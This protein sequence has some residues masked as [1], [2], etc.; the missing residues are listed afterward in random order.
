[1]FTASRRIAVPSKTAVM[2]T[3]LRGK[4]ESATGRDGSS[5][6]PSPCSSRGGRRSHALLPI[7]LMIVVLSAI[8]TQQSLYIVRQVTVFMPDRKSLAEAGF[9]PSLDVGAQPRQE[10]DG[11]HDNKMNSTLSLRGPVISSDGSEVDTKQ[12][13]SAPKLNPCSFVQ[14]SV[15]ES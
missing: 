14:K 2:V 11:E 4:G 1:M 10:L 6:S 8:S 3:T 9:L 7:L 15:T 13:E 12:K 5:S